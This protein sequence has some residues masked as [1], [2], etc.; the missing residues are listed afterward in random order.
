MKIKYIRRFVFLK[1]SCRIITLKS[2]K[3]VEKLAVK[4]KACNEVFTQNLTHRKP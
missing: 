4:T 2:D 1:G 3:T